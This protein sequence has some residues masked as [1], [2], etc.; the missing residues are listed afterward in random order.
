MKTQ[1][2]T[3]IAALGGSAIVS[4]YAYDYLSDKLPTV[5]ANLLSS[6]IDKAF[7]AGDDID[8]KLMVAL[9]LWAEEKIERKFPNQKMG[10]EKYALVAAEFLNKIKAN[11][12]AIIAPFIDINNE[13][14]K[15]VI[16]KNVI[17]MK[18]LLAQKAEENKSK[19]V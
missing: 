7:Y 19:V 11:V 13:K 10:A 18:E 6:Y 12:P 3:W 5:W 14:I 2:I 1:I 16:E 8:D 9:C 4:K 17:K 15:E